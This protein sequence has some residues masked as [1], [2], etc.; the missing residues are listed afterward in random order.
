MDKEDV[1]SA[2]SYGQVP[3]N[4]KGALM[5]GQC[6]YFQVSIV[7]VCL[8]IGFGQTNQA[9]AGED[10]D[11]KIVKIIPSLNGDD[12]AGFYIDPAITYIRKNT[13][14]LWMNGFA[15]KELQVVFREGKTCRDVT[16]NPK[17]QAPGFFLN[18]KSCYVTSS[19]PYLG[20]STLQFIELG[21]YA[22]A[23]Q[24]EGGKLKV[25]G[26]IVVRE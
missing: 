3:K 17:L 9:V 25:K 22:Y 4:K 14:V 5:R 21:E 13:I 18:S 6:R 20:T 15:D 1:L 7:L 11:V 26:K 19:L 24:T 10:S 16:A 2:V 23:V 8:L 12:V